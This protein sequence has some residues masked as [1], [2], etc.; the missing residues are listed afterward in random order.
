MKKVVIALGAFVGFLLVFCFVP[1]C[2]AY[3]RQSNRSSCRRILSALY[4]AEDLH[5][6]K[7]HSLSSSVEELRIPVMDDARVEIQVLASGT[8]AFT[9]TCATDGVRS[10][11]S[12]E[13][14]LIDGREVAAG[15]VWTS[16]QN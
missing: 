12:T 11:I 9:I 1:N 6:R 3:R 8:N 15:V 16:R 7:H 13:R 2:L 5:F 10:T 4:E 14:R